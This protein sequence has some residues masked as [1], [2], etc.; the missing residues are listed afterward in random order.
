MARTG[1][2]IKRTCLSC[3]TRFYD[4]DRSPIICPGCGAEF[5]PKDLVKI[6]KSRRASQA[7][8]LS[9]EEANMGPNTGV[10]QD[11]SADMVFDED[12]ID[13]DDKD[14]P[15]VIEDDIGDGDELLPNLD[16]KDE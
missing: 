13:L 2:G 3:N 5:D 14:G 7:E 11:A 10:D 6:Q 15:G 8:T 1:L 12:D 16:E 4:F 9:E